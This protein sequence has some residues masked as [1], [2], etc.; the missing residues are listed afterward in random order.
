MFTRDLQIRK[1]INACVNTIVFF[2]LINVT[3]DKQ[4]LRTYVNTTYYTVSYVLNQ[5]P[6]FFIAS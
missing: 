3:L 2:H 5:Y 4:N 1:Q 6:L